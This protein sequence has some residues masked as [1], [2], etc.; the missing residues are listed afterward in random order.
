M[1]RS[2][3]RVTHGDVAA[4]EHC[5]LRV[6]ESDIALVMIVVVVVSCCQLGVLMDVSLHIFL[7]QWVVLAHALLHIFCI[8]R[9]RR[10]FQPATV[11]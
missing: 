10:A 1:S 6:M 11:D 4:P 2:S 8:N 7:C 9:L 5:D 3:D